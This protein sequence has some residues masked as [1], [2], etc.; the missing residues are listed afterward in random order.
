MKIF[1]HEF[2]KWYLI[3]LGTVISFSLLLVLT[4]P[5]MMMKEGTTLKKRLSESE[6]KLPPKKIKLRPNKS[7]HHDGKVHLLYNENYNSKREDLEEE[8]Q[9]EDER[10][11]IL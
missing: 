9:G 1:C 7:L 2:E 5:V 4:V 3:H 11:V 8:D 10:N 6:I